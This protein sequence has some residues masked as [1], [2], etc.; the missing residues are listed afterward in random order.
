MS[1]KLLRRIDPFEYESL[2]KEIVNITDLNYLHPDIFYLVSDF[3]HISENT[4]NN[5][6]LGKYRREP[7]LLNIDDAIPLVSFYYPQMI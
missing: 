4:L 2:T 5:M 1:Y 7:W 6:I 3:F